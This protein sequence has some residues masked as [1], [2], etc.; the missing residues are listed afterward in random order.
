VNNTNTEL[1]IEEIEQQRN[2]N[3]TVTEFDFKKKRVRILSDVQIVKEKCQSICYWMS[4]DQR[5]QDNWALLYAQKLALKN[6]LAL[7]VVFCLVP[8]FLDATIRHYDFLI[9]GLRQVQKEC[10]QLHKIKFLVLKSSI[11]FSLLPL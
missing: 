3:L 9:H 11:F 4:R 2:K 10:K 7:K 6:K 1:F 5:V 8:T